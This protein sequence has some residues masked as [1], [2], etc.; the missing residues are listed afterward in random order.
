MSCCQPQTPCE[1]YGS[2]SHSVKCHKLFAWAEP[3]ALTPRAFDCFL[4]PCKL[5][6]SFCR[7][8]IKHENR[9]I[10][11]PFVALYTTQ[12]KITITLRSRHG[13]KIFS[14]MLKHYFARRRCLQYNT[15][16]AVCL[17]IAAQTKRRLAK[18]SWERAINQGSSNGAHTYDFSIMDCWWKHF[19]WLLAQ[20]PTSV[21]S[22][23]FRK[24]ALKQIHLLSLQF[25]PKVK[26]FPSPRAFLLTSN[27]FSWK[28]SH[29]GLYLL[30]RKW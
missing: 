20:Q 30:K 19:Y 28:M 16:A 1:V 7:E 24:A 17:L 27:S 25:T 26:Q 15:K 18:R 21:T 6:D 11:Q 29:R 22:S 12:P 9:P 2:Q 8:R 10:V 23:G 5:Q 4:P 13:N 3:A 14:T